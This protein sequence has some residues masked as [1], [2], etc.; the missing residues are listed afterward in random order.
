MSRFR[1][2]SGGRRGTGRRAVVVSSICTSILAAA[3]GPAAQPSD[4][5]T[6]G[7]SLGNVFE[8]PAFCDFV[9]E[10]KAGF[11]QAKGFALMG[12]TFFHMH[13]YCLA[14]GNMRRA[15]DPTIG[16]QG[17][18]GYYGGAIKDM[19]YVIARATPDFVLLPEIFLRMGQASFGRGD[20]AVALEYFDRS[21]RAKADYWPAYIELARTNLSFGRR[22]EAEAALRAGL[23]ASPDEPNLKQALAQLS[24]RPAVAKKP[25]R[26]N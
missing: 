17:R 20:V 11:D 12:P 25:S 6:I 4:S 9:Q 26:P 1:V 2:L 15:Q 14:L 7:Q 18:R 21:R 10:G 8:L 19:Q 22:Q 16:E 23:E 13:H 3:A 24:A 5:G